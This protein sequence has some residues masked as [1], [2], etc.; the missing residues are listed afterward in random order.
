M[1]G[2]F[3]T[4]LRPYVLLRN[5]L[6]YPVRT[7]LRFPR[8]VDHVQPAG[9][10]AALD[11]LAEADRRRALELIGAYDL[12]P[13]SERGR[14]RDVRE[15][16]YYLDLLLTA[17]ERSGVELP[18]ERVRAA[19]V[20]VSD[21][22][23]A[24]ALHGLLRRY[25]AER[26]REVELLGFEADPGR[27]YAD[28]HTREDWAAWHTQ[29]LAG[30]RFVPEDAAAWSGR[31]NVATM[32]F[33]F[34]FPRDVDRWGLPRSLHR[35]AELL[36]HVWS[37]L[38]PGGFLVVVNQGTAERDLQQ[39]LLRDVGAEVNWG[40]PFESPFWRYDAPR[41]AHVA[42]KRSSSSMP[43]PGRSEKT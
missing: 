4:L 9:L 30:A 41:F 34:L 38:A 31:L 26:P 29:G 25:R 27:R 8:P 37:C 7:R 39:A 19:D 18:P 13:L 14:R 12:Q 11:G 2:I 16:L 10:D 36:G 23:Y 22:F 33:P 42:S 32:L 35:P 24:P 5:R 28:G 20:G 21:W 15:N 40:G 17:F 43:R 1:S 6:D 3:E